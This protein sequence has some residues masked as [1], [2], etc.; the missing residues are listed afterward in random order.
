MLAF[1]FPGVSGELNALEA[2][3]NTPVN[4]STDGTPEVRSADRLVAG[5][6]FLTGIYVSATLQALGG[7]ADRLLGVEES[8]ETESD[9]GD[10]ESETGDGTDGR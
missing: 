10:E 4:A 2:S 8:D 3:V 1:A 5:L 6:V 9:D 7:L